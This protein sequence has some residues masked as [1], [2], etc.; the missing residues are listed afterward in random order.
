MDK[1][2][3]TVINEKLIKECIYIPPS[4]TDDDKKTRDRESRAPRQ[5]LEFFEVECLVFSFKNITLIDNLVG[6]DRLTKLQL[7]NNNIARI[8]NLQ[9]LVTLQWLDLSFNHITRVEGLDTLTCLTD[10]TLYSNQISELEGMDTLTN[11][12]CLSIGKNNLTDLE[13]MAKYLRKFKKLRMLTLS[14]NP[15]VKLPSYESTVLAYI[16]NL[17]YL[18]YRLVEKAKVEK[19]VQDQREKLIIAE[20]EELKREEEL[21]DMQQLDVVQRELA[22]ANLAGMNTLFD[23]MIREDPECKNLQAFQEVEPQ[24]RDALEKYRGRFGEVV[25]EFTAR[26]REHKDKRDKQWNDF[27]FVLST[28]KAET[29]DRCKELIRAFE[30]RKKR[31]ILANGGGGIP[32]QPLSGGNNNNFGNSM[33]GSGGPGQS[34]SGRAD[35]DAQLLDEEAFNGLRQNLDTL[36]EQLMELE[37]DQVEAFEEVIKHFGN[38][39][40]E[41]LEEMQETIHVY[42]EKLREEEKLY[43]DEIFSVFNELVERKHSNEQ[44]GS[45]AA[46]GGGFVDD[47]HRQ[48]VLSMLDNKEDIMKMIN[49]SHEAHEQKMD[50]KE[51]Q[52][53][54]NARKQTETVAQLNGQTEHARNRSRICEINMYVDL[55]TTELNSYLEPDETSYGHSGFQ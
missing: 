2:K 5:Q 36:Q 3:H 4:A 9:H 31:V 16:K 11:L 10:L 7:D 18:D 27:Q 43:Y 26:M 21:R 14:S 52:L 25:E 53:T 40:D 50:A 34:V 19:A 39:S 51:S 23:E 24:L 15:I 55:V 42:F 46:D 28:A 35:F 45:A 22:E 6:F 32:G 44:I 17:K 8:E 41:L 33:S 29:D 20:Q 12:T 30:K 38:L 54:Q 49:E 37:T 1:P 48:Q 47:V 13:A